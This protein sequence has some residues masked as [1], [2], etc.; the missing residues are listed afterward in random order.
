MDYPQI[1]DTLVLCKLI[2][3]DDGYENIS[4]DA[5]ECVYDPETPINLI[6]IPLLG[7]YFGR[8]YK[9]PNLEDDGTWIKSSANKYHFTWDHGKYERHFMHVASRLP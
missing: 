3:T 9:I 2:L 6:I 5:P 4:Y 7:D 1:L 8:K